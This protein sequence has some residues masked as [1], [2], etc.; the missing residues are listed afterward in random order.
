M[1]VMRI[2]FVSAVVLGHAVVLVAAFGAASV[3]RFGLDAEAE[4]SDLLA[5][6]ALALAAYVVVALLIFHG[7]GLYRFDQRWTLRSELFDSARAIAIL[8]VVTFTMLYLLKLEHVSRLFLAAF[9]TLAWL[10]VS[11]TT[12]GVRGFYAR[13]RA[14]GIGVRHVVVVGTNPT[15]P[16]L[17]DDLQSNHP[18]LGIRVAGYLGSAPGLIPG[19]DYLGPAHNLSAVLESRVI[20]EVIVAPEATELEHLDE[21]VRMAHEQGKTTRIPLPSMGFSIAHGAIE[22]VDGTPLLTVAPTTQRHFWLA[23]KRVSDVALAA[24]ALAVLSPVMLAVAV[25]IRLRDGGPVLFSQERVGMHGRPFVMHKFRSMEVGAEARRHQLVALNERKGPA[26]K[27]AD[28]PRITATGRFIRRT[29]LDELPQLWNVLR[30]QMSL[31]GPRPPLPDEVN[32]YDPWHRRRLSM[33]PGMTGLWQVSARTEAGFDA[34]VEADLEYIDNW[35]P[36]LD[37]KIIA[38]TVPAVLK[39]TG[40]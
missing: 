21:I 39:L 19:V 20:D 1:R 10:G 4:W 2:G 12:V 28:D 37:S 14:A 40:T 35:S 11:A 26:F 22:S 9:F 24:F 18:D 7:M 33:K 8:A 36:L 31:V 30:G 38:A 6:P 34:W 27:I 32:R 23:V 17:I 13:R 5:N 3:L 25:V 29:S 15:V 16:R